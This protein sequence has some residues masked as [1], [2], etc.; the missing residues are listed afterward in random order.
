M[1]DVSP[2]VYDILGRV[3]AALVDAPQ[4]AGVHKVDFDAGR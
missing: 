4:T 1:T 3:V 2:K